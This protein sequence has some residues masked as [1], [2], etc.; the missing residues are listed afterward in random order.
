MTPEAVRRSPRLARRW[1]MTGTPLSLWLAW[2]GAIGC[3]STAATS[4]RAASGASTPAVATNAARATQV[5][6][7]F[8]RAL[9]A[10]DGSHLR[11]TV[12][13]VTYPPGGSS[14]PHSHPCP[15]VGYVVRGAARM[16]VAGAPEAVYH[17][18]DT[19]YEEPNGAH[20]VSANA[21][22]TEPVTFLAT[23][24]CDHDAPL[25]APLAGGRDTTTHDR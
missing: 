1:R 23:F 21:S 6:E 8:A 15:V 22:R 24:V 19:F 3:H 18:G 17:A 5:R 10:M 13:E 14:P 4:S 16:Q 11:V 12:V 2:L 9:P 7:P 25:S 20:V